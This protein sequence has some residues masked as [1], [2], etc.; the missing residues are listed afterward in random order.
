MRQN[1]QKRVLLTFFC[2]ALFLITLNSRATDLSSNSHNYLI[3]NCGQI[4]SSNSTD[5][6]AVLYFIHSSEFSAF[7]KSNCISYQF[8]ATPDDKTAAAET[9]RI[10]MRLIGSN[11]NAQ[12]MPSNA[13][14]YT[15]TFYTDNNALP[16]Q[17]SAFGKVTLLNVYD[18]IDWVIYTSPNGLKYDFI[19]H[20]GGNPNDIQIA[21]DHADNIRL[22][23]K[24]GLDIN[25][26][27]G[28]ITE[29]SPISFQGKRKVNSSFKLQ[30]NILSF[31]IG[32]YNTKADLTIDPD[33]LWTTYF[34]GSGYDEV[35]STCS[36]EGGNTY[37]TGFTSATTNIATGGYQT[38]YGGGNYDAFIAKFDADGQRLWC[39]YFGGSQSEFA[40]GIAIDENGSLVI[41]GTTS[42]QSNIATGGANTTYGGGSYDAFIAKFTSAGQLEWSSYIGGNNE[43]EGISVTFAADGS[44]SALL[45][46]KSTNI[47]SSSLFQGN[48][49]GGISDM[50]MS[51][52]DSEGASTWS[53]YLGNSGEEI[54]GNISFSE[55]GF[56][57]VSGS[58]SST[59]GIAMGGNQT[60]Y[61]G[62]EHDGIILLFDLTG[63]IMWSTYIGGPGDDLAHAASFNNFNKIHVSGSTASTSGIATASADQNTNGGGAFDGFLSQYDL[64]GDKI[65]STYIGGEGQDKGYGIAVDEL[66]NVYIGGITSSENN[67]YENGFQESN[68]GG[69]DLFFA[70]YDSLGV[71]KWSSYLGGSGDDQMRSMSADENSKVIF[72]GIT[73]ST[74][75]AF[76]GW[77]TDYAGSVDGYFGKVQDCYNPYVTVDLLGPVDFCEGESVGMSVGGADSFL[78]STGD[79]ATVVTVDTSMTIYVVGT[80]LATGCKGVSNVIHL[81]MLEAPDVSAFPEGPTEFCGSGSVPL[82]AASNDTVTFTWSTSETDTTIIVYE[83]GSYT[84]NAMAANGCISTSDAIEVSIYEPVEIMAAIASDT[85]CISQDYVNMIAVPFG[86]TFVG[87]GVEGN[88][89]I[90][91]QAGGGQ[92]IIFYEYVDEHGCSN[93]SNELYIEVLYEPTLL[94][95]DSDQ[96]C[97][98]DG[99]IGMTGFPEGGIYLGIG[100]SGNLFYPE[101]AGPGNH[102]ISYIFTDENGC[103]NRAD[104]TIFVDDCNGIHEIENTSVSIYPNPTLSQ[105]YFTFNNW[106]AERYIIYDATG[107]EI[108]SA[109][110]ARE[111]SSI[112]VNSLASGLYTIVFVKEHETQL[113]H[114][115]K[116]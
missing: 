66:S 44:V 62:G 103:A 59:A 45:N 76:N 94:F 111:T 43:D 31:N 49:G 101:I 65:W 83:A 71:K 113:T 24:G 20:P 30:S 34:G 15:E 22:N 2:T 51:S 50:F 90:P 97:V 88:S 57:L 98:T 21:F 47:V 70:L 78:W 109:Q 39:T 56:L 100:V 36:D 92:H 58:T 63:M 89:F 116:H 107:K 84:V 23:A 95:V 33:V 79:T 40:N 5:A 80:M 115:M 69:I 25:S 52:F 10:D 1:L 61:G 19:V 102:T 6:D 108:L 110:I 14:N 29:A 112:D 37:I 93:I 75:V 68:A 35:T 27:L 4:K 91:S 73:A 85:A 77:K 86:G 7:I 114:F 60:T 99:P 41:I 13:A 82:T 106:E 9:H 8:F 87:L 3:E 96:A 28:T 48:Y 74:G 26:K 81:N 18:K 16:I 46:T 55:E 105:L 32:A 67:I 72:A 42:S 54:A 11:L 38:T 17:S 104:Q 12:Y 53:S 64:L